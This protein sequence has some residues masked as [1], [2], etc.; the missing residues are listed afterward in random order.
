MS[1]AHWR[2]DAIS[3][4]YAIWTIASVSLFYMLDKAFGGVWKGWSLNQLA[5][6]RRF[7]N[8]DN[9]RKAWM[10]FTESHF[11]ISRYQP[12]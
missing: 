4:E 8:S 10:C 2:N 9:E 1:S 12:I 7:Q 11:V 5:V 6:S 3:M